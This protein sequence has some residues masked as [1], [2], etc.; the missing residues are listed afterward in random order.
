MRKLPGEWRLVRL[1]DVSVEGGKYGSVM[2]AMEFDPAQ[3]RYVRITDISSAGRLLHENRASLPWKYA[4]P[5]LLCEGDLLF[6]R[7]GATVGKTYLYQ[8][9]D[10]PCAHA[11][12]VIKFQIDPSVVLPEY[13]Y[14]W[15][16][17]SSYWRWVNRT[18]RQGAQPNINAAEYG[19][20]EL[21]LPPLNQQRRI[22]EV[23]DA[24]DARVS[25]VEA[26]LS[27]TLRVKQ[28]M[29]WRLSNWSF[30]SDKL[31]RLSD[32]AKTITSGSRGW[33][34]YYAS[35]GALFIR[36]GNLT[37]EH[38]NLRFDNTVY[39][40]PPRGSEGAR[41]ALMPGDVLISI[42]ADLGI[43]G[44]VPGGIGEAYV[45][46]HVS[47]I[48]LKPYVNPRW[49]GHMLASV[50][51]QR[52]FALAND[53]GA[54]AGLN[55]PAVGKIGVP[56]PSRDRQDRAAQMLDEQDAIIDSY[57]SEIGK[58]RLL[59]WGLMGDLLA[60]PSSVLRL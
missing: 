12:Y 25:S 49:I 13:V 45:N 8:A 20:L 41:T 55:L 37:R 24:L 10:G 19:S 16:Q 9:K 17:S 6:A 7:S 40:Q 31:V 15:T 46:Q 44:I 51:G 43:V 14:Q 3:P 1:R 33:S 23:F 53:A 48:R 47:M 11:G 36:I 35:S 4:K 29:L 56:L 58:L 42:T 54:K 57:H 26:M 27:K 32:I 60:R 22:V 39:V 18:F 30:G 38:I 5:Y 59:K 34:Q 50:H 52:Q 2:A 28:G 21:L